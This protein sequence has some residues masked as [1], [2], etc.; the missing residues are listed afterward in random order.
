MMKKFLILVLSMF[1]FVFLEE[2]VTA[3]KTSHV[4]SDEFKKL[5]KTEEHISNELLLTFKKAPSQEELN[6]LQNKF[7]ITKVE[8]IGLPKLYNITL[9]KGTSLVHTAE[10]LSKVSNI[11]RAEPN[12]E[13]KSS[14]ISREPLFKNQ[15]YLSKLNADRAWDQTRG[16]NHV[17]VAVLDGGVQV[18]HPD[19]KGKIVKPYNAVTKKTTF[20]PD[21]HATHVAGIIG[22]SFNKTGIAGIAPNIK[23]MPVNV[24]TGEM[25]NTADI[26]RGIVYAADSGADIINFS[27]G[28]YGENYPLKSAVNYARSKGVILIAAAGNDHTAERTYPAT[29]PG[30]LSISSSD[31]ADEI[32][33]FT[34]YGDY[35]DFAAPG[36]QIYSTVSNSKY[37]Y[38]DGTSMAAPVVSGTAALMLSKNPL[39]S[40]NDLRDLFIK[41]STD[42]GG[43]GWD[44]YYGYGRINIDKAVTGTPAAIDKLTVPSTFFMKGNNY[45]AISFIPYNKAKVSAYVVDAKGKMVKS[46]VANKQGAGTKLSYNWDGKDAKGYYVAAGNYRVVVKT[47][48]GGKTFSKVSSIKVTDQIPFVLNTESASLSF[49]PKL[50]P[51]AIKFNVSKQAKLTANV[52]N[53]KGQVIDT[54][55]SNRMW[56]PGN[57]Y[58][59]WSGKKNDETPYGDGTYVLKLT[60]QDSSNSIIKKNVNVTIDTKAPVVTVDAP[61]IYNGTGY[62][63]SS[64]NNNERG[65]LTAK[66]LEA[67]GN[68]IKVLTYNKAYNAGPHIIN[69]DGTDQQNAP[70]SNGDY[71]YSLEFTDLA[72]NKVIS[73]SST[74]KVER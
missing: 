8:N 42:L 34:N 24:F 47:V 29:Y 46:F 57:H 69:W 5:L 49:S 64:F 67:K 60:A 43:K 33:W 62:A 61:S 45:S 11:E 63:T 31:K 27:M 36:E 70:V 52:Y 28:G 9:E 7:P 15:W 66:I 37:M 22:A 1:S 40:E 56:A 51:Q 48:A 72:G 3:E 74:I 55:F 19:L 17:V 50:K 44:L 39:L 38:M 13:F 54:L 71:R 14:Y 68:G 53:S 41:S 10:E 4:Q 35:I 12:F 6:K 59:Y 58:F 30:V 73:T 21:D 65:T 25:A 32:S 16:E 18:S 26:I 23:I 2:Q 20:P